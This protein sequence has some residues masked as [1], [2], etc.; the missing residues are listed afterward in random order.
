MN[1]PERSGASTRVLIGTL[2]R[3]Q[4]RPRILSMF[5]KP[6]IMLVLRPS[7]DVQLTPRVP[8]EHVAHLVRSRVIRGVA[9]T[10][11]RRVATYFQRRRRGG[12]VGDGST[13]S[14][15]TTSIHSGAP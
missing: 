7:T 12:S 10:P 15:G 13:W 6:V 9:R 3:G 5:E 2:R 4:G 1:K 14:I 8:W 11:G